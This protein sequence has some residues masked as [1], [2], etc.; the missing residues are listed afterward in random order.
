[1]GRCPML[2][3]IFYPLTDFLLLSCFKDDIKKWNACTTSELKGLNLSVNTEKW[4]FRRDPF[5]GRSVYPRLPGNF[6][7]GV[8]SSHSN[9]LLIESTSISQT[10]KTI[11]YFHPAPH[12]KCCNLEKGKPFCTHLLAPLLFFFFCEHYMKA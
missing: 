9:F 10:Q 12:Q 4:L 3:S 5:I 6:P 11:A 8:I 7:R 1:M 2:V